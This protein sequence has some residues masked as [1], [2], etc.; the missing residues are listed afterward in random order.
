MKK[1]NLIIPAAGE[2]TRLKPLSN[3]MSKIMVRVNGKPCLD[4]IIEQAKKLADVQEIVIVD[5][6]FDD[7]REY[8]SKKYP[9]IKFVKQKTL[10][11]PRPAIA[12]GFGKIDVDRL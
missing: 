6:K 3:N 11:G 9:E 4:Y 5:G 1:I 12:L 10:N 8:C 2:A 7:V